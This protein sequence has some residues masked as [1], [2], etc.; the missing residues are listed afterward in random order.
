MEVPREF[1]Q[2]SDRGLQLVLALASIVKQWAEN[3]GMSVRL[4]EVVRSLGK[5]YTVS[6]QNALGQTVMEQH[7]AL[8]ALATMMTRLEEGLQSFPQVCTVCSKSHVHSY[9]NCSYGI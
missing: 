6:R 1:L 8:D 5:P 4:T 9:C 7:C 3:P 2:E